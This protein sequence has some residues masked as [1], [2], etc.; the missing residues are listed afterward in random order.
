LSLARRYGVRI[1]TDLNK[2]VQ[3]GQIYKAEAF[4]DY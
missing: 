2:L 3:S 4:E 1:V